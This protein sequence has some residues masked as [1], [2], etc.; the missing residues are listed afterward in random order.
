MKR[1][2]PLSEL[3]SALLTFRYELRRGPQLSRNSAGC[4]QARGGQLWSGNDAVRIALRRRGD[5]RSDDAVHG[6]RARRFQCAGGFRV[7]YRN[8]R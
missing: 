7:V 6:P 5:C 1:R 4:R 2:L 3:S 8:G